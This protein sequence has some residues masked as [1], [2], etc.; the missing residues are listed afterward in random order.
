MKK[1]LKIIIII[2]ILIPIFLLSI[3]LFSKGNIKYSETIEIEQPIA[4]INQLFQD[5]HTMKEYMPGTKEILL[6]DGVEGVEGAK[7]KI[8]LEIGDDY[9][10][11]NATLKNNNLPDSLTMWYEMPGVLNIMT[12][13]HA[14][15]SKQ[16][17]LIINEQEFQFYGMM[18]IIAFFKPKGF[19][20][21]A[22]RTQSKIYLNAFKQFVENHHSHD[23]EIDA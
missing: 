2:L 20:I 11:M 22:F 18:K 6:T 9:M 16:K 21:E 4:L 8:I 13:K 14:R 5:I 19:N 12:Q 7:Y 10:E 3:L 15:I 1:T 23:A 17:T